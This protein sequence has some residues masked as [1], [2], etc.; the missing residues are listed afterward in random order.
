MKRE[1]FPVNITNIK[2]MTNTTES[3]SLA[4]VVP[5]RME[6]SRFPGKPLKKL[7]GKEMIL[8]VL[9]RVTSVFPSTSTYVATDSL[10]ISEVVERLGYQVVMTKKHLTGTDRIAEANRKIGADYI[11]NVQ[12]DEPVFNPEDITKSIDFLL[13]GDFSVITGYCTS[14]DIKEFTDQNTIKLVFSESGRLLYISRSS[15]PGSKRESEHLFYRQVCIYGYTKQA[16]E[17]FAHWPRTFLENVEDHE[18]LRFLEHDKSVG[19]IPLTDWSV[20]VDVP[21]DVTTAEFQLR[22]YFCERDLGLA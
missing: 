11:L 5:A 15:I 1:F 2:Q 9:E 4:I 20:P 3:K 17:E 22:K 21:S 13:S 6:S 18:L 12:G 8:H 10:E 7:L 14:N 16:L 19:V